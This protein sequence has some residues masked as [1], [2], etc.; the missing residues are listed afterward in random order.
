MQTNQAAGHAGTDA[1]FLLLN[2]RL[3]I[4]C[5]KPVCPPSNPKRGAVVPAQ[6]P[7]RGTQL[8]TPDLCLLGQEDGFRT[9][10]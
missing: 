10:W 1:Y 3:G 8:S 7:R 2:P 9:S 5:I 4:A 6:R